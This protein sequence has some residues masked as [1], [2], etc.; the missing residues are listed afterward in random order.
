MS[1][2]QPTQEILANLSRSLNGLPATRD[3]ISTEQQREDT[4]AQ[5]CSYPP[6]TV[7]NEKRW[8]CVSCKV[9]FPGLRNLAKHEREK[10][11]WKANY[12]CGIGFCQAVY[13][14]PSRLKD[15]HKSAHHCA[16]CK[17][18]N[19]HVEGAKSELP[20]KR[21]WGCPCCIRCFEDQTEFKQ[22]ATFHLK[23]DPY[24]NQWSLGTKLKSLLHHPA[25]AQSL[26]LYP[27]WE[28]WC[29]EDLGAKSLK[30]QANALCSGLERQYVPASF[31]AVY[32]QMPAPAALALSAFRLSVGNPSAATPC[33]PGAPRTD[34]PDAS[35]PLEGQRSPGMIEPIRYDNVGA[36]TSRGYVSCTTLPP[37][38]HQ[39]FEELSPW[40][41]AADDWELEDD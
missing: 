14:I 35:R 6:V 28:S 17:E 20:V 12:C 27:S 25:M 23:D 22:H 16:S 37:L 11:E 21:L 9:S 19:E 5:E 30:P 34:L 13:T 10:C 18:G 26:L 8:W 15:H 31:S 33:T 1:T 4:L 41:P 29:F 40:L 32:H 39:I 3:G 7:S 38:G 2:V 24:L 36:G